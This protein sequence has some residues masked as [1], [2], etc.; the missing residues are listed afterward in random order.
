[1]SNILVKSLI[2]T[3][4]LPLMIVFNMSLTSATFPKSMKITKVQPLFKSGDHMLCNIFRPISLLP[5]LPK[6]LEKIVH[7][8]EVQ[9]LDE[10]NIIAQTQFGF[11]TKHFTTNA[12]S[13]FVGDI[14]N[15]FEKKYF[16]L[17]LFIDLGK[18]FD[19]V[20]HSILL[21]KVEHDGIRDNA[22]NW[23]K[24]YLH[25]RTQYVQI[26]D[27]LSNREEVDN[28]VPQGSV[29]GPVL[30]LI[31]INDLKNACKYASSLLFADDTSIYIFGFNP[32]FM[33]TKLQ[34]DLNELGI[35]L[36]A[37]N[38]SLVSK[39]PNTFSSDLR[40]MY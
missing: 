33:F 29:L 14:L 11:H 6:I 18:V 12:I 4:R 3:T 17:S 15:G 16:C 9:Y 38:Y 28:G 35:G 10:N 25:A 21:E 20:S 1:M 19:C 5:V 34:Y 30:F 37:I 7:Q 22:L 23:F 8:K 31:F 26:N 39:R 36:L 24:S 32:K 40:H 27:M 13:K 2:Y